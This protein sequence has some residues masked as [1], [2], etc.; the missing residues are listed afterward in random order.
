MHFS[1]YV[2]H[3]ET[4]PF[5]DI[6]LYSRWLACGSYITACHLLERVIRQFDYTQTILKHPIVSTPPAL[7]RR[8][9]DD[10]FD[11]YESHL[12]LEKAQNTIVPSDSSYV[13]GYIRWFFRVSDSY[14]VRVAPRYPPRSANHEI[15]EE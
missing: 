14:M 4:R 12:V 11:D 3:R 10:M 1:S 15:L 5:D 9:M 7:T 8:Q 6:V 2:D 13:D